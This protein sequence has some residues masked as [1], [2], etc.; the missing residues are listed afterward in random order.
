[1]HKENFQVPGG[2]CHGHEDVQ[3]ACA[4]KPQQTKKLTSGKNNT[5]QLPRGKRVTVRAP[6][7]NETDGQPPS[8]NGLA[9]Q[10]TSGSQESTEKQQGYQVFKMGSEHPEV[11]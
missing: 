5:E 9:L 4:L 1:M 3:L 2:W 11:R 8:S 7:V 10:M 6:S